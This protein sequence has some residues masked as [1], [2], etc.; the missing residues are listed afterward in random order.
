MLVD[1]SMNGRSFVVDG[2]SWFLVMVE[3]VVVLSIWWLL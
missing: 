1:L 2:S 3:A